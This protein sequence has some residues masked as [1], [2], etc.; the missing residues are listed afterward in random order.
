MQFF[1]RFL[2]SR[3]VLAVQPIR[4]LV[5]SR[6]CANIFFSST[7]IVLFQQQ[8]GLNFTAMF[9]MESILA[10]AIL[11]ADIPTS[12]WADRFGY[13]RMI[14]F[15][16]LCS[17]AG[18]LCTLFAYGFWWFAVANVLGGFAIACTSG[19]ESALFY[20][21]LTDKMREKYGD[22]A[23]ALLSMASTCGFFLGLLTGSF[24]GAFSPTLA[25]GV[26]IV[27][28]LCSLAAAWRIQEVQVIS[29]SLVPPRKPRVL[30]IV[31]IALKTI[32]HQPILIGLKLFSSAAFSLTNAIFWFNQPYFAR[33]GMSV[34]LFG[35]A[36]A[37]AMGCQLLMM[38]RI[39]TF[40]RHLGTRL[41]LVLACLLPG[42]A[43]LLLTRAA[44]PLFTIGL[45]VCVVTFSA[46]QEPLVSNQLNKYIDDES[47]ATTLSALSLV[48]SLVG[49]ALN[50]WIGMLGDRGLTTVGLGMGVSLVLLCGLAPFVVKEPASK[51]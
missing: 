29:G 23:F 49:I 22:A 10:G 3:D 34:A 6:L 50:P 33:A 21:N 7:T 2:P 5:L 46:W 37:L 4:W 45:V 8:R 43:Y 47:R 13:R 42:V 27:P 14:I 44:Q 51:R 41:M 16:S 24:I 17:L 20:H 19:C 28:L 25:V 31:Q 36:M 9:L 48:G 35:P 11:L 1:W 15:G 26:S 12:I 39:T 40:L 38:L 18:M 30:K 32:R